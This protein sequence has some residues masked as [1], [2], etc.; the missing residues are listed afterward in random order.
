MKTTA[1]LKTSA[2]QQDINNQKFAILDYAHKQGIHIDQFIE[3]RIFSQRSPK[4]RGIDSSLELLQTGDTL[5]VS[6]LSRLGRSLGQI[7]LIVDKLVK[8]NVKFIA[9]KENILLDGQQDIQSQ[10]MVS[11]FRLFAKI[12]RELVS[13][14]AKQGLK[15]ARAQG[16]LLGR[17]KGIFG[18]SRLNG[19]EEE[20]RKLLL[21]KVSKSSIAKIMDISRT[22]LYQFIVS[23]KLEEIKET[24]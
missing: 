13:E 19:K 14:R 1:Y 4:N 11:M 9:I 15:A 16:K 22:A 7:I 24:N 3:L 8:N 18:K 21:K 2:D 23:R 17:P 12:E 5:I 10:V 6:E 20:I